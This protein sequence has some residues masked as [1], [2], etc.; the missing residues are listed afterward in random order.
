MKLERLIEF[1]SIFLLCGALFGCEKPTT[2]RYY[3][4][5]TYR[6]FYQNT[7]TG[8]FYV[9]KEDYEKESER[10]ARHACHEH[11]VNGKDEE[12]CVFQDCIFK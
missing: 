4:T 6:C 5:G 9:A 10:R 11:A 7:R 8:Q 2:S 1:V 12:N 3:G